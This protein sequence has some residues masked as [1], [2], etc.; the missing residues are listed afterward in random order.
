MPKLPR[1]LSDLILVRGMGRTPL[2]EPV[3]GALEG[4][5]EATDADVRR[6]MASGDDAATAIADDVLPDSEAPTELLEVVEP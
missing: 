5:A 3:V 6:A 1:D 4:G 2:P